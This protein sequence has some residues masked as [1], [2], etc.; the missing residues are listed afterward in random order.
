MASNLC[1]MHCSQRRKLLVLSVCI[2]SAGVALSLQ[3]RRWGCKLWILSS[4]GNLREIHRKSIWI[5]DWYWLS[6]LYQQLVRRDG[7]CMYAN[8]LNRNDSY[9]L[10]HWIFTRWAGVC[11]TGYLRKEKSF[12]NRID[13]K[14]YRVNHFN[15][16]PL[17]FGAYH[18]IL[19]FRNFIA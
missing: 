2:L 15:I 7:S 12:A 19:H 13:S 1:Y 16:H 3:A 10:F 11:D 5:S 4:R 9:I 18:R 17:N 14:L 6:I 8:V